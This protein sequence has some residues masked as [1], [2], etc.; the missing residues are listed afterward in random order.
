MFDELLETR[1]RRSQRTA[2]G[3]VVSVVI[4]TAVI[5]AVAVATAR[6]S[7]PPDPVQP[8]TLV[9]VNTRTPDPEPS[10]PMTSTPSPVTVPAMPI[11]PPLEI[12][13]GIVDPPPGLATDP[14]PVFA[15]GNTHPA[16][17]SGGETSGAPSGTEP[18]TA[19][20]VE[21]PALPLP[22]SPAP[23]YPDILR[24]AGVEG[25]VVAQFVVD[26]TG[27]VEAGSFRA[28]RETHPLYAAAVERVLPRMRFVAAEAGGRRV[29]QLVQQSF[30]FAM[31][32]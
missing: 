19:A 6:G 7:T 23:V 16:A 24:R 15:P 14:S 3:T 31:A 8:P 30:V 29:R 1:G 4:H 18:W 32:R 12:P 9:Y 22:G 20:L 13:T 10:A 25:E 2:G 21:K 17:P 5:V 11:V 27:R 28:M 26:T